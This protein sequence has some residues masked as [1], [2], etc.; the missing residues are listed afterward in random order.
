MQISFSLSSSHRTRFTGVT[1]HKNKKHKNTPYR[2]LSCAYLLNVSSHKRGEVCKFFKLK[3]D[4]LQQKS[5]QVQERK[6]RGVNTK[7]FSLMDSIC[8][9]SVIVAKKVVSKTTRRP[10][11]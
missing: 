1:I 5:M 2:V 9:A 7:Y 8:N 4:N 11:V 10:S 6:I 3:Q